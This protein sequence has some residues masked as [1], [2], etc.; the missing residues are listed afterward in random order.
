MA[1][2]VSLN[3]EASSES[4]FVVMNGARRSMDFNNIPYEIDDQKG[5]I[6]GYAQDITELEEARGSLADHT[7]SYAETLDQFSS[8][9][10]IF[11]KDLRL[12]YYNKAY[13][14]LWELP[15]SLL[16][17]H[18]HYG[19]ILEALREARRLPEQANFPE[20]KKKQLEIYTDAID[21]LNAPGGRLTEDVWN[22]TSSVDAQP[23]SYSK[24]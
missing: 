18:P 24:T 10:A 7:E 8:A 12:E 16:F 2:S 5:A 6:L 22:T 15:E 3:G 9:V 21:T 4:H 17:S 19:E 11:D 20:W 1:E 23:Y 13:L 14:R